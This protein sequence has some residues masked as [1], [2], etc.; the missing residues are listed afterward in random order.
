MTK[1][2]FACA[3]LLLVPAVSQASLV[4]PASLEGRTIVH[5]AAT[6]I[7]KEFV[8]QT[9]LQQGKQADEADC[10]NVKTKVLENLS[11]LDLTH[12]TELTAAKKALEGASCES[13]D[14]KK[15]SDKLFTA[16]LAIRSFEDF[17]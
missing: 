11:A 1:L 3:S 4:N 12:A 2:L 7:S 9:D 6:Q 13:T 14:R 5:Q 16:T 15:V 17:N 10:E 8:A